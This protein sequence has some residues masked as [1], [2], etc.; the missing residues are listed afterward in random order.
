MAK[1]IAMQEFL[2]VTG[3]A[4][5]KTVVIQPT[6]GWVDAQAAGDAI[7]DVQILRGHTN[8]TLM[9]ET[10]TVGQGPWRTIADFTNNVPTQEAVYSTSRE[11]G[12][13]QFERLLRWKLDRTNVPATPTPWKTCFKICVTLK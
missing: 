5:T 7:F 13:T 9:L 1:T 2:T 10:A 6:N 11:N 12:T 4:A 8:V 3:D